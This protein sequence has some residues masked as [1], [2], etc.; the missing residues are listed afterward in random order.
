MRSLTTGIVAVIALVLLGCSPSPRIQPTPTPPP[1]SD[2]LTILHYEEGFPPSLL[3]KF[4][5]ETGVKIIYKTFTNYEEGVQTIIGGEEY[6]DVA[7][8]NTPN[9]AVLFEAG[10]LAPINYSELSNARYISASFRDLSFNPGN[11]HHVPWTWGTTGIIYRT[12]II[13]NPPV[14]WADMWTVSDKPTG[15]WNDLRTMFGA[16]LMSLGY[17]VNTESVAEI[18]AA[19]AF[20][21]ERLDK[22]VFVETYDPYTAGYALTDGTMDV[23]LG[24]AYDAQTALSINDNI[25]YV[26]PEEG[27]MIWLEVMVIPAGSGHKATAEAFMDFLLRPENAAVYTNEFAYATVVDEARKFIDPAVLNDTTIFPTTEMLAGAELLQ[28]I[29]SE[30]LTAMNAHWER[31][32]TLIQQEEQ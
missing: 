4:E 23:S 7:W 15:A 2:T 31:L 21:E 16:A 14:K 6:V 3:N 12:D 9:F 22:Q 19:A 5:A 29:S 18:D 32:L 30:A 11:T 1:L 10:L 25:A 13:E 27:T 17:S 20:L 8:L 24:W 26:M 28:P